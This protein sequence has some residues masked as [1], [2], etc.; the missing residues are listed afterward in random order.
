MLPPTVDAGPESGSF[1]FSPNASSTSALVT[2]LHASISFE[3]PLPALLAEA[4]LALLELVDELELDPELELDAA[5]GLGL[6]LQE[7]TVMTN[8]NATTERI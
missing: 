6:L 5:V 1:S 4:L 2:S 8:A 3:F 7:V